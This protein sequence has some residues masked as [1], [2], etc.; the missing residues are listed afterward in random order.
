MVQIKSTVDITLPPSSLIGF[1]D[2][3]IPQ[4]AWPRVAMR[5][6][7]VN[8]DGCRGAKLRLD[9]TAFGILGN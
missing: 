5:N 9:Y 4:A 6:R 1:Q 2:L 8:Q 3:N 7:A